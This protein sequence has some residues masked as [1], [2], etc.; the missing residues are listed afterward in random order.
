MNRQ[1]RNKTG[2]FLYHYFQK[3]KAS[4]LVNI[5]KAGIT[6]AETDIHKSRVDLKKIF[7]LIGFFETIG[8]SLFNLEGP[9]KIFEGVYKSAGKI[10]EMQVK[11]LYIESLEMNDP[12]IQ[13]FSRY[14]KSSSKKETKRFIRAIIRFDEK[15]LN[16]MRR[17]IRDCCRNIEIEKIIAKCDDFF[18]LHSSRIKKYRLNPGEMGNVHKIRIEMKKISAVADLLYQLTVDKFLDTLISALNQAELIIGE[19]HD[20][21]VLSQSLD[22]FIKENEIRN[23]RKSGMLESV[24]KK[25]DEEAGNLL[26]KLLPKVDNIVILIAQIPFLRKA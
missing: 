12:E 4:F 1:P 10:R 5:Y 26:G 2:D 23:E 19:W 8:I 20:R 21:V 15:Q 13:L 16:E 11:L 17:S 18:Q 6:A 9:Q 22:S 24:K 3:R 7:A 25:V 14:L